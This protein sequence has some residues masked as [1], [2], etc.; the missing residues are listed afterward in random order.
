MEQDEPV[1]L[2]EAIYATILGKPENSVKIDY[3]D[4]A[5]A[6]TFANTLQH[7]LKHESGAEYVDVTTRNIPD[8]QNASP[9]DV[10]QLLETSYSGEEVAADDTTV[11]VAP[12]PA[13]RSTYADPTAAYEQVIGFTQTAP[14]TA[15]VHPNVES[16]LSEID[17]DISPQQLSESIHYETYTLES[18]SGEETI[19]VGVEG[20]DEPILHKRGLEDNR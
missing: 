6:E 3:V 9:G 15:T 1:P 13:S 18:A 16:D 10:Q 2:G 19:L 4:T 8:Y 5:E 17:H 20:E 7:Q 14:I 11:L 12:H